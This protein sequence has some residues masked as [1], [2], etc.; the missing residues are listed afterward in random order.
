MRAVGLLIRGTC[1][2]G[3]CPPFSTGS[4]L[5]R[6]GVYCSLILLDAQE[7]KEVYL[8]WNSPIA[9]RGIVKMKKTACASLCSRLSRLRFSLP[10]RSKRQAAA[11]DA[12]TV[13][14]REFL[15][16]MAK[17]DFQLAVRDFDETMLKVSGP[18]KLE[19]M[20]TKQLPAQ[21]GAFKQ[22][23]PARR[24]QMQ[25]YEIV[26]ITCSF[27]KVAMLDAR[28]V[29]DKAGKIAGFGL[30]ADGAAGEI[31]AARLRRPGQVRGDRGHGRFGRMGPAG[32][33]DDA[34]GPRA[35]PR[36][37]PRPRL[38]PERPGRGRSAPT[39]RSRTWPGAWR[40]AA[41]PS[42]A[43]TSAARSTGRRSW[44]TPSSKR[45]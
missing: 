35:V 17:G 32:D 12:L 26:L 28:V 34:E 22:Q 41:S 27:E 15:T 25:G 29:F 31:R 2:S 7:R 33:T 11:E 23:G 5:D 30:R 37:R 38:G 39:S 40:R 24:E 1:T 21:L 9:G 16:A 6:F 45:P 13:K 42:S 4:A 43:T 44:P 10:S 14:A 3:T 20:W 8:S 18:D 19:P 36:A